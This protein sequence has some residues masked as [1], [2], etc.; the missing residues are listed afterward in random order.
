MWD[1]MAGSLAEGDRRGIATHLNVCRDCESHRGEVRS[2]RTGLKQLPVRQVPPVLGTRLR[3]IASRER[4]RL[5]LRRDFKT[6]MGEQASRAKLFFDHLFKPFALPAA[7]GIL[8][9]FLC[10]GVIVDTLHVVPDWEDDMP[11]GLFTEISINELSPFCFTGRDVMVQLT[12]DSSGNVT[13]YA[14]PQN[15]KASREEQLEIGNLVFYSSFTP[16]T[17]FGKPVSSKRLFYISH[18]SIKG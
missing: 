13:D 10:F 16:A 18:I 7:G 3:V 9:S 14:L 5:L 8:A 15:M 2:L 4:S 17:R 12:V 6:W 11:I 1:Y